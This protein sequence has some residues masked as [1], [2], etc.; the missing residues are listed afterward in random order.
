MSKTNVILAKY[1]IGD[2]ETNTVDLGD[3]VV[4]L[5]DTIEDAMEAKD[6]FLEPELVAFVEELGI[7]IDEMT[8][9][10]WQTFTGTYEHYEIRDTY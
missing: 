3:G 6:K 10:Q 5:F 9:E 7:T 1:T 8:D 4:N 2:Y